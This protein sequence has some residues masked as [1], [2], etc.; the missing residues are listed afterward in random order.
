MIKRNKLRKVYMAF[1][2]ILG[3][4]YCVAFILSSRYI[5][6]QTL[7]SI[8]EI[9]GYAG[10]VLIP[11]VTFIFYRWIRKDNAAA[12]DELE[13]MVLTRAFAVT[14]LLSITLAPFLILLSSVFPD[15]AGFITFAYTFIIGGT[16]KVLTVILHRK[17]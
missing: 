13:Q 11:V 5:A 1:W 14:G 17:Y 2:L 8:I 10:I 12:S 15:A 9:V 4:V 7:R 6:Q 3:E 16:F